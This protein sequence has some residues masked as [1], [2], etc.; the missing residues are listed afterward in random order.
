MVCVEQDSFWQET[1]N[2]RKNGE[3]FPQWLTINWVD[4]VVTATTLL[5]CS[6]TSP[7]SSKVRK[8]EY[9][10]TYDALIGLPTRA[11]F[12]DRLDLAIAQAQQ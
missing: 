10:A 8:A 3:I 9:L 11:L 12:Q 1:T 6:R 7:N 5:P 2:R 4:Q